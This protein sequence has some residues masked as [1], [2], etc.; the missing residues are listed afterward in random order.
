MGEAG[1]RSAQA[2]AHNSVDLGALYERVGG[3]AQC[4]EG[5]DVRC[6]YSTVQY[7]HRRS[8]LKRGGAAADHARGDRWLPDGLLKTGKKTKC[9]SQ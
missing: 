7:R 3:R 8:A 1:G 9:I 4:V 5:R 2:G 6:R